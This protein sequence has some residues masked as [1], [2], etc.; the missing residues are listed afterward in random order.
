M[1]AAA[2]DR[3]PYQS[4]AAA[5]IA[6]IVAV[7]LVTIDAAMIRRMVPVNDHRMA[8]VNDYPAW[9]QRM[10]FAVLPGGG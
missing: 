3:D 10:L 8:P 2:D 9:R 5:I 4:T 6:V 7:T 1:M